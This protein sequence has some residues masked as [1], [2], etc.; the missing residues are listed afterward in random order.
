MTGSEVAAKILAATGLP[1]A[2]ETVDGFKASHGGHLV[3]GIATTFLATMDTLREAHAKGLNFIVTHE[4]TFYNHLDLIESYTNDPVALEKIRFITE[5]KL[6]VWRF[7]DHTHWVPQD[8]IMRGISETLG[9]GKPT[10]TTHRKCF[11]I[12]EKTVGELALDIKTA[13][14]ATAIRIAGKLDMKCQ[15]IGISVGSP[16]AE[17]IFE[18]LRDPK[19]NVVMT[20]ETAEWVF[21][22]YVWDM[23]GQGRNIAMM[24]LG[25]R[26]SEELGVR[27]VARWLGTQFPGM[28]VEHLAGSD[29][30]INV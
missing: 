11:T 29:P 25:H 19:I 28:K 7:H 3:T 15:N 17:N 1:P 5:H 30:L 20:G 9:W 23:I 18:L 2:K 12:P 10:W 4:P 24:F 22:E 13:T 26:N 27:W 8:M 14:Q 16:V 21:T 6:M